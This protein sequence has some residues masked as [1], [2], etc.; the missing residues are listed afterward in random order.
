MLRNC[1]LLGIRTCLPKSLPRRLDVLNNWIGEK[2]LEL[3]VLLKEVTKRLSALLPI[4]AGCGHEWE[5]G[6]GHAR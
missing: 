1:E 4:R 5:N 2:I 3:V 6:E